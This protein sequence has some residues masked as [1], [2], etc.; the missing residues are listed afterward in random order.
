MNVYLRKGLLVSALLAAAIFWAKPGYIDINI[1]VPKHPG[2]GDFW[3]ED[4][5]DQLAY[6]DSAGVLYVH[7][8]VGTAYDW[9]GWKTSEDVFAFFEQKLSERG[10]TRA[11]YCG[12]EP[13]V[14]ETR[15]LTETNRR[16]YYRPGQ[17][18]RESHVL[19]AVWPI[20]G[21]VEGFHVVLTAVN[22][23]LLRRVSDGLD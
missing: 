19:I 15:L 5:Y 16:R 13:E 3:W 12:D 18:Y 6:A 8:Q 11:E 14:P 7:R 1:H 21:S 20:G 9:H 10:W 17:F 2:G 4:H 22:S 23:S